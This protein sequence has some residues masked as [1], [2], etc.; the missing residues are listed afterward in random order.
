MVKFSKWRANFMLRFKAKYK[1]K[2][3][4]KCLRIMFKAEV[5]DNI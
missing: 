5:W 3:Q 2:F 1:A 4:T